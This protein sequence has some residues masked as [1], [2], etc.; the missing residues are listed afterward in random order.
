VVT[1]PDDIAQF[2]GCSSTPPMTTP[3]D[4]A[5]HQF[6]AQEAMLDDVIPVE[7]G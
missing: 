7:I 3:G 5:D 4:T 6:L 1:F 2:W